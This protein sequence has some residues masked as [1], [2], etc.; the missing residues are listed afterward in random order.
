MRYLPI[1]LDVEGREAL[2]LGATGEAASKIPRLVA[3]GARVTV[4]A[5]ADG[6]DP[7]VQA[8]ADSGAIVLAS[9]A[10]DDADLERAWIVFANPGDEVLEARLFAWAEREKRLF[11]AMDRPRS[12]TFANPAVVRPSGLTIAVSSDGASPGAV[13]RIREDLEAMFA[14]S[15]FERFLT[16]LRELRESLPRGSRATRLRAALQGFALEARIRF[17]RWFDAGE[18]P[19]T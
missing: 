11:C 7:S 19:P 12:S 6:V 5:G 8:S 3:A 10:P 16:A 9:R 1:G 17:P 4:L 2:V 18:P 14:D 15:R 13:R